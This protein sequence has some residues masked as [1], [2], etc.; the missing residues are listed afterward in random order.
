VGAAARALVGAGNLQGRTQGA[1]DEQRRQVAGSVHKVRDAL[2]G[3]S[4]LVRN[5]YAS[6]ARYLDHAG[7]RAE[8]VAHYIGNADLRTLRGDVQRVARQ[9][10]AWFVG[11]A[12]VAGLVLGRLFKASTPTGSHEPEPELEEEDLEGEIDDEED[13]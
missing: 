3:A 12:F 6:V 9:N 11:G 8:D 1:I 13:L 7:Q 5:D 2:R 4:Q 10:P